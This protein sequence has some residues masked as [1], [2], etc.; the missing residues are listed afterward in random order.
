[1][2]EPHDLLTL[3]FTIQCYNKQQDCSIGSGGGGG[4][5]AAGA[6]AAAAAAAALLND[7]YQI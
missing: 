7:R 4:G 5:G 6:A 3:A 2:T 1:M